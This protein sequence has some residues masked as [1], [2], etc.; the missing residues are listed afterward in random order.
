MAAKR[1]PR[2]NHAPTDQ[3][4]LIDRFNTLVN[5]MSISIFCAAMSAA[6][7][8]ACFSPSKLRGTSNQ[9][10]HYPRHVQWD[11]GNHSTARYATCTHVNWFAALNDESPCRNSTNIVAD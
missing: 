6:A 7:A 2:T 1:L 11:Y 4:V 10:L 3:A 5:T 9:P 8:A